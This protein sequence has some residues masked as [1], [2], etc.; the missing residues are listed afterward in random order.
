MF[1][2]R[3]MPAANHAD[4][5][6]VSAYRLRRYGLLAAR[7]VLAAVTGGCAHTQAAGLS[8]YRVQREGGGFYSPYPH[9]SAIHRKWYLCPTLEK[10]PL[11]MTRCDKRYRYDQRS[12]NSGNSRLKRYGETEFNKQRHS[13]IIV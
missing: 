3:H 13:H 7:Y 10:I 4:T 6:R 11:D 1:A 5:P 8:S 12:S 9:S 2:C